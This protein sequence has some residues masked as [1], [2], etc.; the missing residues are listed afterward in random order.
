MA[1]TRAGGSGA[2]QERSLVPLG[3][4]PTAINQLYDQRMWQFGGS[5]F[6][7]HGYWYPATQT[8]R[9]ACENL[10]EK[11]LAF[12]PR[13]EGRILDVA[14]GKGGTTR[15]LLRYYPPSSV[16]AINISPKQLAWCRA[17]VPGC[18][19]LLMNATSMN[20]ENASFDNVI[21]VEAAFHFN[22]REHFLREAHRVLK[23]GG[24]LVLSDIIRPDGGQMREGL[25]PSEN[26]VKD[27]EEYRELC[28]GA[29][30]QSVELHDATHESFVSSI[31]QMLKF[32]RYCFLSG[33]IGPNQFRVAT[34]EILYK[35]RKTKYYVLASLMKTP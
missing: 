22:T 2:E 20:F 12:I 18:R 23:P 19:F 26:F 17:R 4:R 13:K 33:K 15:Y 6:F 1:M 14:C 5:D 30:F 29:G 35:L 7:N 3:D 10:M 32:Q 28:L 25:W 21:C 8:R 31:C 16:T 11:L 24:R 27:L 9:E 34:N